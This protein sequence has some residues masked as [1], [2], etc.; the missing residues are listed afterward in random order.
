MFSVNRQA[1]ATFSNGSWSQKKISIRSFC[2][3]CKM[4]SKLPLN[5]TNTFCG[6]CLLPETVQIT[7]FVYVSKFCFNLVYKYFF[8]A[9]KIVSL[10]LEFYFPKIKRVL[11]KMCGIGACKLYTK[12]V[13]SK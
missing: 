8:D 3:Q 1:F 5:D 13:N 7:M 12:S 4:C 9:C 2:F 11:I 6:A 10:R